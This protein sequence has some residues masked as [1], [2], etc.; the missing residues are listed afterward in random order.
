M[1]ADSIPKT[2]EDSVPSNCTDTLGV[3]ELLHLV[4]NGVI[5]SN[6]LVYSFWLSCAAIIIIVVVFFFQFIL[7]AGTSSWIIWVIL[8]IGASL[9]IFLGYYIAKNDDKFLS[10]LVG[11]L[12]GF[13]LG[14]LLYNLFGNQISDFGF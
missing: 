6:S 2:F 14:E 11:C 9:G 3:P 10:L 12:G 8:F 13:F 5:D 4:Q 7:P 1:I